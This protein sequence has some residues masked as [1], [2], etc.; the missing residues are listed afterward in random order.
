MFQKKVLWLLTGVYFSPLTIFHVLSDQ[1][2]LIF[3]FWV[4]CP[5]RTHFIIIIFFTG[6]LDFRSHLHCLHSES[7]QQEL[8]S[9][10]FF[11]LLLSLLL[12]VLSL[13][14]FQL[15]VPDTRQ[16]D[17]IS[18][19]E[20]HRRILSSSAFYFLL[21]MIITQWDVVVERCSFNNPT[22]WKVKSVLPQYPLNVCNSL[23]SRI[24]HLKPFAVI[25]PNYDIVVCSTVITLW[26][27]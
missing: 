23:N 4:C 15:Y 19:N 1:V 26:R 11:Y 22:Q 5:V 10:L 25:L 3:G 12:H 2:L 7:L 6:N 14:T 8:L 24:S 16:W 27:I 9:I 20:L 21:E 18:T 13:L 17:K